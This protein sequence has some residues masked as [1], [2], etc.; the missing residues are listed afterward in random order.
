[1]LI[2]PGI[3]KIDDLLLSLT[4]YGEGWTIEHIKCWD[5]EIVRETSKVLRIQVDH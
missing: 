5:R 3:R 2:A 1:M 4:L